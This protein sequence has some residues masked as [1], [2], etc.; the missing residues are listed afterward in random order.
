[1]LNPSALKQQN[2]LFTGTN[3]VLI[4]AANPTAFP[5]TTVITM[6]LTGNV[7]RDERKSLVRLRNN[8]VFVEKKCCSH[9]FRDASVA[10]RSGR[11]ILESF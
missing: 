2:P 5:V 9:I 7:Q 10:A 11:G 3:H 1:M 4:S 8:Q 6:D